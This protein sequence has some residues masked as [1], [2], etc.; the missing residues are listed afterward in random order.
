MV[1]KKNF[2]LG[3][4]LA[5]AFIIGL[6]G[7]ALSD[8]TVC[9]AEWVKISGTVS[10]NG[11]PL[12]A[13]VLANGQYIFSCAGDGGYELNVP[14]DSNGEITLFAF[15]DG[16]APFKK[17]LNSLQ[18]KDFEISMSPDLSGNHI[19]VTAD[20]TPSN[21]GRVKI[22]GTVSYNGTPL[23]AMVLAN[24]QYMFSCAGDGKYELEVPLDTYGKVTLFSFCDGLQPFKKTLPDADIGNHKPVVYPASLSTDLSIPYME[25]Q[26]IASD[27]DN[28]RLIYELIAPS[29]GSG[30]SDAF[31]SPDTGVLYVTLSNDGTRSVILPYHVSD[32][33]I[34]SESAEIIID[35][36]DTSE[37]Q[38]FGGNEI[39]PEVYA[40][41]GRA[42]FRGN[43]QG[44]PGSTPT[45]P[46][47]IDLSGNFPSPGDQGG[48][49]SCSGWATAYALKTYQEKSEMGWSLNTSSHLFSPAFVYNQINRGGDNGAYIYEALELIVRKGCATLASMPYDQNDYRTQPDV[50]ASQEALNFKA[51]EFKTINSTESIKSALVNR[52]AVVIGLQLYN[53]FQ[54][55]RGINS[56]YNAKSGGYLG[57]HFVTITGYDDNLYNGVF[58]VIN[59][60]GQ[61]WGDSGYFWL[62]Y[63]SDTIEE[64]YILE[65]TENNIINDPDDD[66]VRP[67]PTDNM[68]NF[69]VQSWTANYNPKPR[70]EGSLQWKVVNTG[71]GT[72]PAGADVNFMLSKDQTLTSG[73]IYV[74]YE[75]I[76]FDLNPGHSV[77]RDENN[78][79]PFQFPDTL[80]EG[81][82]YMAVWIDDLNEIRESDE[83]DNISWGSNQVM[84]ENSLPDIEVET[85]YAEW[86]DYG[87][88]KLTYRIKNNGKSIADNTD[89]DINLVLSPDEEI[90]NDNEIFLF[91]EDAGY[92]LEPDITVYRDDNSAASF[93]LHQDAF[94]SA[95]PAG[96]Y[97]MAVWVDDL[98]E[99]EESNELNNSSI[100]WSTIEI[101]G[102]S[103]S[104]AVPVNRVRRLNGLNTIETGED[105]SSAAGGKAYNG[106]KLPPSDVL[107]RKVQIADTQDGG[108]SLKFLDEQPVASPNTSKGT[109]LLPKTVSSKNHVIFPVAEDIPMQEA[110]VVPK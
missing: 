66:P 99:V 101:G 55:L 39:A 108:R 16:L 13:M 46:S 86:D 47:S 7:G 103:R 17:V 97:Y 94:G 31:I 69:E 23:C 24:G 84:I 78:S 3:I 82:Y 73:D 80:E 88:G 44:A 4:T 49:G 45:M 81:I 43:L 77:Y 35:I 95:V 67:E 33:K 22:S 72:A 41:F 59:S 74:I 51:V 57:Y 42:V 58:R 14:L 92:S 34:F 54:Q 11:T 10:Y 50:Q 26:L 32:G 40:G 38:S 15:C 36:I 85:W 62:P 63:N 20:L 64:A 61:D 100:G 110:V 65:D 104:A 70:G 37:E 53:S 91:Y 30:Y 90:G 98:N 107:M 12:C 27:S 9:A 18:A 19:S 5:M 8:R 96:T 52:Q 68:P 25:H 89:W 79:I 75:E 60:W 29:S 71:T 83:N 105:S 102:Y 56:V 106:R 6:Q 2:V 1:T 93:Y 28:D 76:Q 87:Y 21:S 48:Q 109:V